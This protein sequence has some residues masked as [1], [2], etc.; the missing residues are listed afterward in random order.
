MPE[1][2]HPVS[3][4]ALRLLQ[5]AK[6]PLQQGVSPA[7]QLMQWAL[8][9]GKDN[10]IDQVRPSQSQVLQNLATWP[11]QDVLRFLLRAKEDEPEA[12]DFLEAKH[13]QGVSPEEGAQLLLS[14]LHDNLMSWDPNYP[15]PSN[16]R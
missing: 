10:Q 8:A 11:E 13:F 6:V 14:Q 16:L 15:P 9:Q 4:Q 1:Q 5:Q 2:S 3:Q 12:A 7:V